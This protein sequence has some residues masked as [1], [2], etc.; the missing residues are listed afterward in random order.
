MVTFF[1]CFGA[2][3]TALPVL[4]S[5]NLFEPFLEYSFFSF[6]AVKTALPIKVSSKLNA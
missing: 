6:D 4:G 1:S 5:S 3:K 2:V